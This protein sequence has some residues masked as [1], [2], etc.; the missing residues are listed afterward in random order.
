MAE[1]PAPHERHHPLAIRWPTV[2]TLTGVWLYMFGWANL[3]DTLG[4]TISA[5][6]F[7]SLI[8][9]LAWADTEAAFYR[10]HAFVFQY[11][12]RGG[13]LAQVL[14]R[15]A[16][17]VIWQGT[18]SVFVAL[19]LV[20]ATLRL[21]WS[22]WLLLLTD[23]I[24]LGPLIALVYW[25]LGGEVRQVYRAAIARRW[26]NRINSLLLW[27]ALTLHWYYSP[28][29]N[30]TGLTWEEVVAF[31]AAQPQ[32]SCDVVAMLARVGEVGE[33]YMLWGAQTLLGSLQHEQ[34]S[35]VWLGFVATFGA[36][37][38]LSWAYGSVLI[39]TLARPGRLWLNRR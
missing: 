23:A 9:L 13:L 17:I 37:F 11:L 26:A 2:L 25:L 29:P 36:F 39:G 15:R 19:F 21:E 5:C 27:C 1:A 3:A 4:C 8:F 7:A 12:E 28:Q 38:L 14:T 24:L 33:A 10:R 34:A 30:Y 31:S 20:V 16:L 6:Y 22:Q 32:A 18:K 35:L